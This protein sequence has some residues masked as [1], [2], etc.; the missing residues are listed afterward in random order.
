VTI[1][2][3]EAWLTNAS[4]STATIDSIRGWTFGVGSPLPGLFLLEIRDSEGNVGVGETFYL[5][6]ACWATVEELFAR[7]LLGKNL[8]DLTT[9]FDQM[10][11]SLHRLVGVGAEFR[12]LSALDVALW[13]LLARQAEK[14]LRT[15]LN[16]GAADCIPVYN[17]CAGPQYTASASAPGEGTSDIDDPRDDYGAWKRDAGGLAQELIAEGYPA[18]KLWPLDDLAKAINGT[19]P[20]ENQLVQ[21]CAPLQAIR[22]VVGSQIG[23]MIDGH[24]QWSL[25]GAIAVARFCE[26]FDLRWVEDLILAHPVTNL[27]ILRRQTKIPVLASEYLATKHEFQHLFDTNSVDIVMIDPTWAGGITNCM[28]VAMLAQQYSLPVSF[29]DCTGPATLMAGASMASAI[30]NHEIQEVA[31]SFVHYVYPTFADVD[32]RLTNGR[33]EFGNASGI[34]VTLN[35][36]LGNMTGVTEYALVGSVA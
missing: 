24:G 4:V 18:M 19:V 14:P 1:A 33:L 31:R 15:I 35:P 23:L 2:H 5:P 22:D 36:E 32:A 27:G 6:K 30:P 16:S 26:R 10:Q 20:S 3:R 21:A 8:S 25:D 17:S 34:G 13:D 11:A 7:H 9:F 28:S 29:H 12:T